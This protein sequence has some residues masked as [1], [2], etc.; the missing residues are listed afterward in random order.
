MIGQQTK[1]THNTAIYCRLSKDDGN[2]SE[3]SSIGTQREMLTRYVR[4]QGWRLAGEYVDDLEICLAN[5][6]SSF[7]LRHIKKHFSDLGI[8]TASR[9]L[10]R[11]QKIEVF[12]IQKIL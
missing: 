4:E 10:F 7:Y 5:N 11:G 9:F 12:Y 1:K 3:S 6:K 2:V 8:K